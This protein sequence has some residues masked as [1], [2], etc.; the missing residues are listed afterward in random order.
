MKRG[1]LSICYQFM[2]SKQYEI[3]KALFDTRFTYYMTYQTYV[4]NERK[5]DQFR[6]NE[7][8]GINIRSK[9]QKMNQTFF[10]T[11][12]EYDRTQQAYV[13]NGCKIYQ[14]RS[15]ELTGTNDVFSFLLIYYVY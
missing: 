10:D 3:N 5:T 6:P 11:G 14:F 7:Q 15:N 2:R 1:V 9:Q 13:D 4:D 8:T 12:F